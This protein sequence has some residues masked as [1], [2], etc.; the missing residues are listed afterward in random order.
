MADVRGAEVL[1]ARFPIVDNVVHEE[2]GGAG[3]AEGVLGSPWKNV[4]VP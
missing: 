2:D 4:D 3:C 1:T